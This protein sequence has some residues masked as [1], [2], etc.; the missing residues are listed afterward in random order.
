LPKRKPADATRDQV[1]EACKMA[2][3]HDFI[4]GLP[5]GYETKLGAKGASLSGGQKQRLAIARAR[6][7]DP[8]VLVLGEHEF[9][10]FERCYSG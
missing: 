3:M 7:R 2:M 1:I 9:D 6:L 4:N 10:S 8:T 5:Q